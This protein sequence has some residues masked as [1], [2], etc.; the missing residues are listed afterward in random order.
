VSKSDAE[1]DRKSGNF[2]EIGTITN[3]NGQAGRARVKLGDVITPEIKVAALRAGPLNFWWMPAVGEQ[4]LVASPGGD[5]GQAVIVASLYAGN[6]PSSDEGVPMI[7]LNGGAGQ[8]VVDGTLVVTKD[9]IAGGIS[10][11]N[12]VHGGV[13]AGGAET[14]VPS[15]NA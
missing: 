15:G 13:V 2:I 7:D 9:V 10:L 5:I 1:A 12:H 8:M 11:V 14:D 6:A 4:V 3:V